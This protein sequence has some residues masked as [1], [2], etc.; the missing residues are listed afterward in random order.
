MKFPLLRN[1]QLE[2]YSNHI[3]G[4]HEFFPEFEPSVRVNFSSSFHKN[5][6][7]GKN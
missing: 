7:L 1:F 6:L 5:D 4:I 2:T 3:T